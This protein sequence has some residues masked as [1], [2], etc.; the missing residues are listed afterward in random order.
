M[1]EH[2][3]LINRYLRVIRGITCNIYFLLGIVFLIRLFFIFFVGVPS[4]AGSWNK[5]TWQADSD[6][7]VSFADAIYN[8]NLNF[9]PFRLPGYPLILIGTH[10]LLSPEW[11]GTI[12]LQQ[13]ISLACAWILY[14][15][16]RRFIKSAHLVAPLIF[17]FEP[18]TLR[19]S[20]VIMP[21]IFLVFTELAATL[22]ILKAVAATGRKKFMLVAYSSILLCSGIFFKPIVLYAFL[23]YIGF[24]LVYFRDVFWKRVLYAALFVLIFQLPV[25]FYRQFIHERFGVYSLTR[26]EYSEKA[27]RSLDIKYLVENDRIMDTDSLRQEIK[28][29]LIAGG[30]N[31]DKPDY[32]LYAHITDSITSANIKKYPWAFAYHSFAD[33]YNFFHPSPSSFSDFFDI[34][35][36]Y[37]APEDASFIER[38]TRHMTSSISYIPM[39]LYSLFYTAVLILP[40]IISLVNKDIRT[41]YSPLI[42]FAVSWFIY[43][44]VL[45]GRIASIRYRVTFIWTF[46]VLS[47]AVYSYI[48][49]NGIKSIILHKNQTGN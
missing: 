43:S 41:K 2:N 1:K 9:Y 39:L 46:T 12:I 8:H 30:F 25:H 38:I 31:Y 47:G 45:C 14:L 4:N 18:A 26:Q 10:A 6:L 28:K 21:E 32:I 23:L 15:I 20:F 22:V 35:F 13:F 7:Y 48:K 36:S 42:Y 34:H 3:P 33:S 37:N 44:A 19:Y 16:G 11:L 5:W 29:T 27:G 17:L 40:F 49:E 24:I